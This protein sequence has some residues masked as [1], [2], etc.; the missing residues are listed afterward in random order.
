[1]IGV[2]ASRGALETLVKLDLSYNS[3]GGQGI[4]ALVG[5]LQSGSLRSLKFLIFDRNH[6]GDQGL[7]RAAL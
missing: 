4:T 5:S 6:I 1:M 7:V 3:I 2:L